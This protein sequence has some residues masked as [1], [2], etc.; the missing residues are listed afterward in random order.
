MKYLVRTQ[1][2]VLRGYI[3]EA[4]DPK[5][6]ES[7]S[8]FSSPETEEDHIEETLLIEPVEATE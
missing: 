4:D 2:T 8:T 1:A 5:S 7:A 3:V 6:A